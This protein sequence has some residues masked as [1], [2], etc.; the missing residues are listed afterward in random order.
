MRVVYFAD[1]YKTMDRGS[2]C[3]DEYHEIRDAWKCEQASQSLGLKWGGTRNNSDFPACYQV[4]PEKNLVYF[5]LKT[6]PERTKANS[7]Y[8]AICTIGT[9]P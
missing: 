9:T 7:K 2:I 6:I 4:E 5:N 1:R 8:A 3:S